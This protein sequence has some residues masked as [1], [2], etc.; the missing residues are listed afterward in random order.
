MRSLV[1]STPSELVYRPRPDD[2]RVT[3]RLAPA[4]QWVVESFPHES[5][6]QRADG[7]WV[8]VLPVS[9]RAWLE[10]LVLSLGPDAVVEKPARGRGGGPGRRGPHPRPLPHQCDLRSTARI[11][12][13]ARWRAMMGAWSGTGDGQ[14]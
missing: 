11:G 1:R 6:K 12:S 13:G 2:P 10:R 9:E 3:L 8:V 4:A 14:P 7:S 5:A